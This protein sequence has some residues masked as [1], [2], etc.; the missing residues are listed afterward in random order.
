MGTPNATLPVS[1]AAFREVDLIGV[2]RY[3][4]TYPDA[5]ALFGAGRLTN[6]HKLVTQRI[7]LKN[8]N[9]AFE[10]LMKGQDESG[11]FVMKL[12]VGDY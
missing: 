10:M 8:A 1:A 12:M 5:L 2:F 9:K 7:N 11:N 3:C 4:N 6:A